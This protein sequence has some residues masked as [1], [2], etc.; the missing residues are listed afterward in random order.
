MNI[1]QK[2]N[3]IIRYAANLFW[4]EENN[5][6]ERKMVRRVASV[7]IFHFSVVEKGEDFFVKRESKWI[8]S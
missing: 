1:R 3:A 4:S 6:N 8:L 5:K 7:P 2:L